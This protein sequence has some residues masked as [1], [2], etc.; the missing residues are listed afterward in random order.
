MSTTP[1]DP[2]RRPAPYAPGENGY[3]LEELRDQLRSLKT[4]V[5]LLGILVVVSLGVAAWALLANQGDSGSSTP[6]GASASRVT[7]LERRVSDLEAR[8]RSAPSKGDLADV[9]AQQKVLAGRVDTVEKASRD[10]ASQQSVDQLQQDV[11]D[12]QKRVDTLEQQPQ[13]PAATP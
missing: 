7:N 13:S 1:D 12:L 5:V 10:A 2:T 4:A 6:R 3:W 9:R 11:R 8:V